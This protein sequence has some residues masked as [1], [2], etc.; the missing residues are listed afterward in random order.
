MQRQ[1]SRLLHGEVRHARVS[2]CFVLLIGPALSNHNLWDSSNLGFCYYP[3]H[4]FAR[5]RINSS[6]LVDPGRLVGEDI[7]YTYSVTKD[8]FNNSMDYSN[9]RRPDDAITVNDTC[10]A[11]GVPHKNCIGDQRQFNKYGGRAACVACYVA[12]GCPVCGVR[13][14]AQFLC[15]GDEVPSSAV[16]AHGLSLLS[17][18]FRVGTVRR[19]D[20]RHPHAHSTPQHST[21]RGTRHSSARHAE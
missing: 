8:E 17:L 11:A 13:C 1:S 5:Y 18:V 14:Y 15:G 20:A 12:C 2:F 16:H 3:L 10:L 9:M 4:S 7:P 21:S 19:P 6:R